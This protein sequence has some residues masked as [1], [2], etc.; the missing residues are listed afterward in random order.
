MT[1]KLLNIR[2]TSYLSLGFHLTAMQSW[3]LL[4]SIISTAL[5]ASCAAEAQAPQPEEDVPEDAVAVA[6]AA[7]QPAA[8]FDLRR[9]VQQ[10]R[11][12][13]GGYPPGCSA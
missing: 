10:L 1:Y 2:L 12:A 9:F 3:T 5:A 4:S 8:N 13:A 7:A 11:Q 6:P